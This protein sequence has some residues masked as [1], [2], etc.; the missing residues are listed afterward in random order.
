MSCASFAP[1]F[2]PVLRLRL[3]SLLLEPGRVPLVVHVADPEGQAVGGVDVL[4][5]TRLAAARVASLGGL[6]VRVT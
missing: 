4:H 6:L 5:Q 2:A 1:V 3:L